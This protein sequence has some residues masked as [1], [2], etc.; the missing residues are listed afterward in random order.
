MM[1]IVLVVVLEVQLNRNPYDSWSS[2]TV[3]AATGAAV[4]LGAATHDGIAR[5]LGIGTALYGKQMGL[6][7]IC[8]IVFF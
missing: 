4:G 7:H 8:S 2:T 3:G 6:V 5:P 1:L